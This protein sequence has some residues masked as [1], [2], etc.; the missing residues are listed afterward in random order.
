M[1]H[2]WYLG[3]NSAD[4]LY[5]YVFYPIMCY[6]SPLLLSLNIRSCQILR[7]SAKQQIL[8]AKGEKNV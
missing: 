7:I 5:P 8:A 4:D 1:Q 2:M 6:N 3:R